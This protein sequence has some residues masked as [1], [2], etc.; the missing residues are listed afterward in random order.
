MVELQEFR[1]ELSRAAF[2]FLDTRITLMNRFILV[3]LS[4]NN[5]NE[6]L[7]TLYLSCFLLASL[8]L[9]G[10]TL[11][12]LRSPTTLK[13]L[14]QHKPN[15]PYNSN[16]FANP[17]NPNN[18]DKPNN[19]DNSYSPNEPFDICLAFSGRSSASWTAAHTARPHD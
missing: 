4:T 8:Q 10:I 2:S 19:S 6:P 14:I 9:L 18:S 12:T 11:V 7:H 16:N 17:D 3:S 1:L 13:T 5:P 15:E